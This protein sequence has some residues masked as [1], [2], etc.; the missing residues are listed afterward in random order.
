MLKVWADFT[1][2]KRALHGKAIDAEDLTD[3]WYLAFGRS[4]PVFLPKTCNADLN[5]PFALLIPRFFHSL[6]TI[7][8]G[9]YFQRLKFHLREVC[10]AWLRYE[11]PKLGIEDP[12][13]QIR[14][15]KNLKSREIYPV[16]WWGDQL[17]LTPM[18]RAQRRRIPLPMR[19]LGVSSCTIGSS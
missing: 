7:G 3:P 17:C 18:I 15:Y 10:P 6:G 4:R 1:N 13:E 8:K 19:S 9:F 12:N 11:L 5:R 16:S 2:I 14:S